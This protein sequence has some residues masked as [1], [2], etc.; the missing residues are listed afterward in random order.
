MISNVPQYP[1]RYKSILLTPLRAAMTVGSTGT[2]A[3]SF[4]YDGADPIQ[5]SHGY[6]ST[7]QYRAAEQ[8]S[9]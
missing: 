6:G 1:R 4:L 2:P 5:V 7:D 3:L 9:R 8:E